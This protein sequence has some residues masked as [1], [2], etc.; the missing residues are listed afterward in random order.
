MRWLD[1]III[2]TDRSLSKLWEIVKDREPGTL[3][4]VGSQRVRYDLVTE[5]QQ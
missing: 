5:Q 4:S 3:Q 2:S 1:N